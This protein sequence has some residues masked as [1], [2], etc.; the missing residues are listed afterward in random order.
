METL[1]LTVIGDDRPGIVRDLAA[2]VADHGGNWQE[3][4]MARL[5]GKFAGILEARVTPA[6]AAD[7]EAALRDLKGDLRITVER[8]AGSDGEGRVLVIE[9]VGQDRPGLVRQV[10]QAVAAME[11]NIEEL[12]SASAPAPMT[13]DLMFTARLRV[14]LAPQGSTE[15]LRARLEALGEEIVVDLTVDESA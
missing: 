8:S 13:G 5:A 3:S 9:L 7:L 6:K 12:H 10:S 2:V 15:E 4:R 1:I 11:A 14:R